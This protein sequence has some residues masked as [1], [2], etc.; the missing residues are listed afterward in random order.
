MPKKVSLRMCVACRQMKEKK[1]LI[2]IIKDVTG[3]IV[4]DE[5]VKQSGRGAYLCKSQDCFQ[6][7]IKTKA[8]N[9]A[10]SCDIPQS[11]F[12]N[13]KEKIIEE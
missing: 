10:L 3:S 8:L 5:K 6:K 9:R 7:C 11:V 1:D 4:V 13:L 2:R 12:E